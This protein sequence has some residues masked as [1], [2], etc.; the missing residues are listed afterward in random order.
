MSLKIWGGTHRSKKNLCDVTRTQ[1]IS[2]WGG[3]GGGGG[4]A[5]QQQRKSKL[6]SNNYKSTRV[7]DREMTM[8]SQI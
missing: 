1:P 7:C 8:H 2:A 5:G 4:Q 3:G 6:S